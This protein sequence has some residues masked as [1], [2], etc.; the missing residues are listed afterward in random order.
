MISELTPA[1]GT[2]TLEDKRPVI[3]AA[4]GNAGENPQVQMQLNGQTVPAVYDGSTV[5]YTPAEDLADG[6]V[7]V[8]VTVTRADGKTAAAT[9]SFTVGKA[10]YQL[11]FGQ[12]HSHTQYSDGSG[13]LDSAL[14]YVRSCRKAPMCSLSPLRITPTTST[15]PARPTRRARCTI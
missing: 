11:Y 15:S 12:L 3:S 1:S 14:R 9:W 10:Q 4:I 2:E 13:T 6:R 5:R 8:T 7:S